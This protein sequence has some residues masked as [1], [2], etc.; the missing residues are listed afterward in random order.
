VFDVHIHYSHD[1]WDKIS[2]KEAI[3]KLRE[4][5]ITRAMVS[6]SSDEGTQ[7]LYRA[8]PE[9]I[10]PA[11]RPYRTRDEL[12]TWMGDESVLP[13]LEQ[14]LAKYR[15]AAIGEFHLT[16]FE[17]DLPVPRGLVQLAR[18]H[19]LMLHAHIDAEGLK[20]LFN[21]DPDAR[22]LWAHAGFEDAAVVRRMLE[23]Y[24]N[25]W[26]DLSFRYDAFP[27][28]KFLPQWKELL[29][30][31]SDRFMLGVDPY[32]PLRWL[33]MGEVMGWYDRMFAK[34]PPEVA[35]KIRHK[36]ARRVIKWN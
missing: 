10:V 2:P 23:R 21:Q 25:L 32:T 15:Y 5:G 6:S 31:H 20:R 27:D 26:A 29:I 3:A 9:M 33:K 16:N 22:I 11:L 28:T 36:N 8:A 14:R 30:D 13:Y 17:A 34:L 18:K 24:D 19:K 35:E 4:I 7:M 1:V 12:D